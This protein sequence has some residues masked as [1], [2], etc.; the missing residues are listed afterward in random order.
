MPLFVFTKRK[1]CLWIYKHGVRLLLKISSEVIR[2]RW[3]FHCLLL[4]YLLAFF[5]LHGVHHCPCEPLVSCEM[6]TLPHAS[7]NANEV[8]NC[9]LS[10][11]SEA[12]PLENINPL[13]LTSWTD[14]PLDSFR[15]NDIILP[16]PP[17]QPE[18]PLLG[19]SSGPI[20]VLAP[21]S[22]LGCTIPGNLK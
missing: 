13:Q 14:Q 6:C 8:L 21:G 17:P 9:I 16:P 2:L 10:T 7:F 4:C 22:P 19:L 18:A 11:Q 1:M 12:F 15:N 3:S 5:L 20:G